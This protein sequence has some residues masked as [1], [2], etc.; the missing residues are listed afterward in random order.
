LM[1]GGDAGR[2]RLRS[3]KNIDIA[4]IAFTIRYYS[5]I[6]QYA[7]V[8]TTICCCVDCNMLLCGLQYVAEW[9]TICYYVDYN[10]LLRGLQ[11]ATAWTTIPCELPFA[12]LQ[13]VLSG[14]QLLLR[15]LQWTTVDYSGLQW[16]TLLCELPFALLRGL[17]CIPH[18]NTTVPCRLHLHYCVG[19]NAYYI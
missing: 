12:L 4:Y 1:C 10:M 18:L 17:Q 7:A 11:Y 2:C 16:T 13:Y 15:G 6:L 19:Y 3:H 9:T 8:W 14:L 5:T